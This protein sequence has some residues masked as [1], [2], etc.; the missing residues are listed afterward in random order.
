MFVDTSVYTRFSG[1]SG[2]SRQRLP[3]EAN[4]QN[5]NQERQWKRKYSPFC[6]NFYARLSGILSENG[7]FYN[8]VV[9]L[10]MPEALL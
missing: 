5:Q 2:L 10:D 8:P 6:F 9:T 3:R 7:S 4:F 1:A